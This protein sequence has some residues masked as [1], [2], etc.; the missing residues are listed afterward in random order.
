MVTTHW[1]HILDG[2]ILVI[3]VNL[4]TS[5]SMNVNVL[6]ISPKFLLAIEI[7]LL[8]CS[9]KDNDLS[10]ITPRSFS[11]STLSVVIVPCSVCI[12]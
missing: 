7:L 12:V 4:K 5:L 1:L 9:P 3:C 11:E 8:M 6:N 10:M 2:G